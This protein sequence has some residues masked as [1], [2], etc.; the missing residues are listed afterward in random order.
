[1]LLT[2]RSLWVLA[3]AVL[4]VGQARPRAVWAAEVPKNRFSNPS[5]EMGR[6]GWGM[7]KGGGTVASFKADRT[8][9]AAG[10]YSALVTVGR[11][12]EWGV[13][14][15]QRIPAG[16]RGRTYT[17]AVLARSI[18]RPV[19][20]DLQIER[21]ARPYDRAAKSGRITLTK[22]EWAELHVTFTVEKD[23]REG[24]FA[25]VS[26]AQASCRFRVDMFRLYEGKYVPYAQ[27][28][29]QEAGS[30]G[31]RLFDTGSAAPAPISSEALAG[32]KGWARVPAGEVDRALKGDAVFLNDK[33]AVALRG[34]GR[35]AEVYSLR[36]GAPA[37]RAVLAPVGSA[38]L[39]G[40]TIAANTADA[41][42]VGVAFRTAGGKTATVTCTLK[43]GQA[44]VETAPGAGAEALRVHAPCRFAVLPDFF[45]DDI[46]VDATELSLADVELPADHFLLHMLPGRDAIV[47]AVRNVAAGDVTLSPASRGSGKT[48]ESAEIP[49]GGKGK[50]WVAV[51]AAPGI[52]HRHDVADRDAGR[53]ILLD[54]T[55]PHP[56]AWRVDWRKDDGLTDS[57]EMI[58]E[59]PG[60]GYT[61][62]GWFGSVGTVGANR[63]R[64]TTVLGRFRYPCWMDRAGRGY[65][66]PLKKGLRFRGPALIYPISRARETSLETFTVVDIVRSTL[67]V[68]PCEYI[69]DLEG[70]HSVNRGIATCA[71]RSTLNPIYQKGQQKRQ[72]ER[73]EKAL[74]DVITF[75]RFIRQRIEGYVDFGHGVR[76][77][78]AEQKAAHPELA[79]HI[80]ELDAAARA[81]DARFAARRAKI[82]TPAE[83]E[84]LAR[85][86]R[87]TLLDYEGRDA[88]KK[89][90]YFTEAW[91]SIGGNQDELVG[92]CR[93]AVKILRQ[94]ASLA[95]AHDPKMAEIAREIRR[96]SHKVLRSPA[97]HEGAN[98]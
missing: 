31:V 95:V 73:I 15:G 41:V 50:V 14:F 33:L 23:F 89:C 2:D 52:W 27:Q 49:Y 61:K 58:A 12:E 92:E 39:S 17:F 5:F 13:Q 97:G 11:V 3:A 64:W 86:F 63:S 71:C 60:G 8:D 55:A 82:R 21:A 54:W 24:W 7:D 51:L 25:Y 45:A 10:L 30:A 68:G 46:V 1:M 72:R 42:T 76:E 53:I 62:Y 84:D 75:I 16:K 32:R 70:Q 38:G 20:V 4:A 77:Y 43:M 96:R 57:W 65:L 80:D 28:A 37:M 94:R 85:R 34:K 69:L 6:S 48:I 36:G 29:K 59:R 91:V 26:C 81:I 83:A 22:D 56:A 79:R 66:Q 88:Y 78:L 93:W 19:T 74:R 90:R 67:G 47:M 18:D 9:A 98:H 35:G 87:A 44:Y 40:V